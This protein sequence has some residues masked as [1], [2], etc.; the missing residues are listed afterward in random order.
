VNLDN[1]LQ[2]EGWMT[3]TELQFL[4]IEASKHDNIVEIGS[5]QGRSTR[6]L[7][8]NA[9]GQ[10]TA[11][12]T[13]CGSLKHPTW[14]KHLL[15]TKPENWL[16]GEFDKNM[17]GANNLRVMAMESLVAAEQLKD[18][19]FDM[20]FID[21]DHETEECYA[22]ILAW[23]RM[24]TEGGLICGHD[25]GAPEVELAVARAFSEVAK[26]LGADIWVGVQKR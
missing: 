9:R 3:E 4:A 21:D 26:V 7:I 15:S 10:V 18:E 5:W 23:S 24:L 22:G 11:V 19:R 12:D 1:A 17:A 6:A 2:I 16:R 25:Y 14:E 20:I 8:D 13:F